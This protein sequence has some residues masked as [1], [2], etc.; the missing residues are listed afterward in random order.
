MSPLGLVGIIMK[1]INYI[2]I[3]NEIFYR[4]NDICNSFDME[5]PFVKEIIGNNYISYKPLDSQNYMYFINADGMD[6]LCNKY[7]SEKF[8]Y[9]YNLIIR[10]AFTED[11]INSTSHLL[12][13]NFV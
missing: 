5:Y 12:S 4:L 11:E 7:K 8:K 6:L 9:F 13:V 10:N 1:S 3:N 2:T